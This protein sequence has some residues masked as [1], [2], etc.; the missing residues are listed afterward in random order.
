MVKN[1]LNLKNANK[2]LDKNMALFLKSLTRYIC[3]LLPEDVGSEMV[4][5]N[6]EK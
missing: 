2:L 6:G 4:E 1:K 3:K 5:G